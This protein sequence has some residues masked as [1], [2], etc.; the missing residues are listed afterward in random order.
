MVQ[1]ATSIALTKL[2]V[3]S[4]LDKIP[5]CVA[6]EIDGEIVHDFPTGERLNKAKPVYEYFD[7]FKTDITSA[8]KLEDLPEN[9]IKYI[10]YIEEQIKCKISYI[11]VGPKRE[12]YIKVD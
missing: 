4:Y 9:A 5:V 7:G 11:S 3:L 2:D 10:K 12:Q 6:Y 8:R 1:G